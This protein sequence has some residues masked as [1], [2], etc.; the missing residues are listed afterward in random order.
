MQAL[1]TDNRGPKRYKSF[2]CTCYFFPSDSA[3]TSA[4]PKGA[5]KRTADGYV[6][7]II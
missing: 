4:S 5:A 3:S 7:N 6:R 1:I 2:A